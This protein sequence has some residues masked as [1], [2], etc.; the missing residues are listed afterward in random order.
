MK[1][2]HTI[3]SSENDCGGTCDADINCADAHYKNC[4]K[5]CTKVN[6]IANEE[7]P[8]KTPNEK[9]ILLKSTR[10]ILTNEDLK[11][12]LEL[13]FKLPRNYVPLP[14]L[15]LPLPIIIPKSTS[16]IQKKKINKK[17][18]K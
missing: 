3:G 18:C 16:R 14:K 4:H 6:V 15:D 7:P 8:P 12:T 17:K 2:M 1:K 9:M 11:S 5:G 10:Q 13:E